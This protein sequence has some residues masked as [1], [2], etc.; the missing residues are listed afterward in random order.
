MLLHLRTVTALL[1]AERAIPVSNLTLLAKQYERYANVQ[2]DQPKQIYRCDFPGCDRNFV[3]ADLCARHRERHTAKGSHLQR[4]DAFLNSQRPSNST[5]TKSPT[6]TSTLSASITETNHTSK[7]AMSDSYAYL[8]EQQ[9]AYCAAPH[10]P[11]ELAPL[12]SANLDPQIA[13]YGAYGTP[14]GQS[15]SQMP[16]TTPIDSQRYS[17]DDPYPGRQAMG[18]N[19]Y[20]PYHATPINSIQPHVTSPQI[21]GPVYAP[22]P[23]PSPGA[24]NNNFRSPPGFSNLPSLPPF[25]IP[26]G[27]GPPPNGRSN[28]LVSPPNVGSLDQ[29]APNS[30]ETSVGD[31][32]FIDPAPIGYTMPVFG[33]ET[34]FT[35]SPPSNVDENFLNMLLSAN[36]MEIDD[37]S[38]PDQ[39]PPTPPAL[40][41]SLPLPKLEPDGTTSEEQTLP[42]STDMD[43][44][45]RES[46]ITQKKQERLFRFVNALQEIEHNPGRKSKA[47][48]LSG[49]PGDA[50]HV[51]SLQMLKTYITSYWVRLCLD[52]TTSC[53]NIC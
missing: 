1:F 35:R 50:G 17:Y 41:A 12:A 46:Q 7:P 25:G 11:A 3:R 21:G 22:H 15:L 29:A 13:P 6:S 2:P 53:A 9:P 43:I 47:E 49:S 8:P 45:M 34:F 14:M 18:A 37:P 44:T 51:M 5:R 30:R 48:L 16:F 52:L 33:D 40:P 24:S 27:Y 31:F 23:Y 39:E 4:K 20:P 19:S 32:S 42:P 28:S 36:G 26:Q 38:P 10:A